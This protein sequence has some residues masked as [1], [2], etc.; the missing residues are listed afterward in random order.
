LSQR[1]YP[2]Q[3][4]AEHLE[5]RLDQL[6]GPPVREIDREYRIT[7]GFPVPTHVASVA[8]AVRLLCGDQK[9]GVYH[10]RGN[11]CGRD[12]TL[13]DSEL[14]EAMVR[15]PFEAGTPPLPGIGPTPSRPPHPPGAASNRPHLHRRGR[16]EGLPVRG[17]RASPLPAACP[18]R[19]G[20]PGRRS[21]VSRF[22]GEPG[23]SLG[24]DRSA[25]LWRPSFRNIHRRER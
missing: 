17:R 18:A 6:M 22:R 23:P 16:P 2:T 15:E 7:L 13:S 11:F 8:R 9:L 1:I 4:L 14:M 25:K 21:L 24:S 19:R 20:Q 10:H 3:L 5:S 12:P